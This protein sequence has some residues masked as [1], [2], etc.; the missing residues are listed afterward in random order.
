[1]RFWRWVRWLN[2]ETSRSS[3][4]SGRGDSEEC[5]D[6][7]GEK[8][9]EENEEGIRSQDDDAKSDEREKN[10]TSF[11]AQWKIRRGASKSLTI[12]ARVFLK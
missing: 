6:V 1:M 5:A 2:L 3:G 9:S 8:A 12:K 11:E 10:E 4:G 7:F